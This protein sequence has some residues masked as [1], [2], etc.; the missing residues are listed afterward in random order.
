MGDFLRDVFSCG[1]S[2]WA[3]IGPD[4]SVKARPCAA[5]ARGTQTQ[6]AGISRVGGIRP[7]QADERD[8]VEC[9][10]CSFLLCPV[11]D[12]TTIDVFP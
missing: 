3:R 4:G 10:R 7:A 1:G 11:W 8:E 2:R 12:L 6:Y 9:M 5:A